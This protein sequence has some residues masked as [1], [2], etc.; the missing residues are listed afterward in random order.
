MT[1]R[2]QVVSLRKCIPRGG[3][4]SEIERILTIADNLEAARVQMVEVVADPGMGK[5]WLLGVVRAEATEI[6]HSVLNFRFTESP[7]D[8]PL[9]SLAR[10]LPHEAV[11]YIPY[12][13]F[14]SPWN[15]EVTDHPPAISGG[16]AYQSPASERDGLV[17]LLDDS[18]WADDES[19]EVIEQLV[20]RRAARP[21]LV[22]IARRSRQAS[23]RLRGA[24]AHGV[25][26]GTVCRI[27]LNALSL[28][29]SAALVGRPADDPITASLHEASGGV[30]L[31]LLA[32]AGERLGTGIP[33]QLATLIRAEVGQLDPCESLISAT[34]AV[35][36][37]SWDV[38]TLSAVAEVDLGHT[39]AALARLT[40]RDLVRPVG[41]SSAYTFR[42][43]IVGRLVYAEAQRGWQVATHRL[44]ARVLAERGAPAA[45]LASHVARSLAG[46]NPDDVRILRRAAEETLLSDP[47]SSIS[48]VR[49][50][51]S[52]V[53]ETECPERLELMLL[54][55]RALGAAGRLQESR[56]LLHEVLR[57]APDQAR[58]IRAA[59]VSHCALVE[60]L[61]GN[62]A[63]ARALLSEELSTLSPQDPPREAA[64]LI[65]AHG[66]IGA[67]DGQMPT[68]GQVE[69][70]R[71]L[72]RRHA[73]RLAEAGA[74]ALSGLCD[75]FKG[76]TD[77]AADALSTAAALIDRLADTE[78]VTRPEY[79][80]MLAWGEGLI[81]RIEDAERHFRRGVVVARGHVHIRTVLLFGQAATQLQAGHPAV[82]RRLAAEARELAGRCKADHVRGLSLAL[83]SLAAAWTGHP[84]EAVKL[85]EKAEEVLDERRFYWSVAAP[86]ALGMAARLA[87]DAQRAATL[88]VNAGGCDLANVPKILRPA[89]YETLTAVAVEIAE[90][91]DDHPHMGPWLLDLAARAESEADETC[92]LTHRAYAL[93]VRGHASRH[94]GDLGAALSYYREAAGTFAAAGMLHAQALTLVAQA[95]CLVALGRRGDAELPLLLAAELARRSGATIVEGRIDTLRSRPAPHEVPAQLSSLTTRERQI[96]TIA[97][98]GKRTREIADDLSL[99]PRTVDAH[100]TRIYRK[101]NISSR[102]ALAHII[103]S[104]S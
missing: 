92:L 85:G 100:L 67:F 60:C 37:D 22:V 74:H 9:H 30:P 28:E 31:Y 4:R 62:Y 33:E 54:L 29:E 16:A 59:C 21:L 6:G 40:E 83:E 23:A 45:R 84:Q 11:D 56:D 72:A 89:C 96:A 77:G 12:D 58:D 17:M 43:P 61:L 44:A 87:G 78:L 99:S 52:V 19:I 2:N 36:D 25:E 63:E 26:L 66:L 90:A 5:T 75:G 41:D 3:R 51:L 102:S 1:E 104:L 88:L 101:L 81:G 10:L 38:E 68:C 80:G 94:D 93:A 18:H 97:A 20:H 34:A 57:L 86:M 76:D 27:E 55:T 73:D 71:T 13:I 70:A 103:A 65:I 64:A 39:K 98:R 79:I 47:G 32:L 50:A 35:L 82:A 14:G 53:P 15:A 91:G 95:A 48:W 8:T 46:P 49:L 69:R 42:H 24:L 7:R